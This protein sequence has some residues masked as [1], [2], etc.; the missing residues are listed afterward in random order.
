MVALA[1]S[2]IIGCATTVRTRSVFQDFTPSASMK[3]DTFDA[4]SAALINNGFE[5]SLANERLGIVNTAYRSMHS[6]ADTAANVAG[7]FVAAFNPNNTYT[8]YSRALS[9]SFQVTDSGY[10]VVPKLARNAKTAKPFTIDNHSTVEYPTKDSDEG[11]LVSKIIS[12]INRTLG[13]SD[14]F[15]WEEKVVRVDR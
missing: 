7:I 2:T 4:I 1:V 12:E 13:L 10:R 9:L 3:H 11:K 14:S 15:V 5:I 8:S 6:G